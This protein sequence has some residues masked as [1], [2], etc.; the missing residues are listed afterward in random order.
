MSDRVT[1]ISR[2]G[3]ATENLIGDHEIAIDSSEEVGPKPVETLLAAY[4]SCFVV[5]LR[6][7]ARDRGYV[8]LGRIAIEVT[9]ERDGSGDL[10]AIEFELQIERNLDREDRQAIV[11]RAL[12]SCHVGAALRSE[13]Q[14]DVN[15]VDDGEGL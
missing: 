12:D 6:I 15:F 1:S 9:G 13:L 11:E 10:T 4:A 2:G 7:A 8:D 3:Y 14:A 5:G